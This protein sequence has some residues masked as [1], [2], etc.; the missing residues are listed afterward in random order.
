MSKRGTGQEVLRSMEPGLGDTGQG[1]VSG[2]TGRH[3]EPAGSH[4]EGVHPRKG[5]QMHYL[6][7]NHS[8]EKSQA[9]LT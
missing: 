5:K 8:L 6:E 4:L 2:V 9:D 7:N 3:R 1:P